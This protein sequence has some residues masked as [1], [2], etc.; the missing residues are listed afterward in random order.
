MCCVA[1]FCLLRQPCYT[2]IHGPQAAKVMRT[3]DV[4]P[5]T[6]SYMMD[7]MENRE[8]GIIIGIRTTFMLSR[9]VLCEEWGSGPTPR[10]K[11]KHPILM[12]ID[13]VSF[14]LLNV[15]IDMYDAQGAWSPFFISKKCQKTR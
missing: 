6:A 10:E 12:E 2:A 15:G 8:S 9:T 4:V 7:L 1:S 13:D 5:D 11:Q 3:E 14:L